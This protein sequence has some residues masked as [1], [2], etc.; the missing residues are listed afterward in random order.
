ME[1]PNSMVLLTQLVST[2]G[3]S[4]GLFILYRVLVKTKE[5][6]I[7]T[8]EATIETKQAVIEEKDA[9]IDFLKH[10][11]QARDQT[12]EDIEKRSP[13]VAF[14]KLSEKNKILEEQ[15]SEQLTDNTLTKNELGEI[16]LELTR[17]KHLSELLEIKEATDPLTG[18]N[19]RKAFNRNVSAQFDDKRE[20]N[21]NHLALL[22][23]DIDDFR[24]VND[25]F[26]FCF[27]DDV[28][29]LLSDKL[30]KLLGTVYRLGGD[31]FGAV[32]YFNDIEELEL[33]LLKLQSSINCLYRVGANSK[34]I[35]V[36]AGVCIFTERHTSFDSLYADCFGLLDE[37]KQ[38][39]RIGYFNRSYS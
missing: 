8:K 5:A 9:T 39:T 38:T 33:R 28:L 12:I 29:V 6:T 27:G 4:G 21:F 16:K 17:V 13:D 37:T 22:L 25:E 32:L 2:V 20:E 31:E 10:Q 15:L 34:N 3:L 1:I 18:A 7:E 14:V 26:G 30:R 36:S 35:S 24:Q 23:F 11:L 19:N